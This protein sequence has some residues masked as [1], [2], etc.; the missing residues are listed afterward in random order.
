MLS[1]SDTSSEEIGRSLEWHPCHV[2]LHKSLA[3]QMPEKHGL[4]PLLLHTGAVARKGVKRANSFDKASG[5]CMFDALGLEA[6][7]AEGML[8]RIYNSV[9]ASNYTVCS[10]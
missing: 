5:L 2:K 9:H 6:F 1:T 8:R 7:Y 10:I 3:G 4:M